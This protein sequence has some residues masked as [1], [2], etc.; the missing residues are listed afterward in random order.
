MSN[1]HLMERPE[2]THVIT[3][4]DV[5]QWTNIYPYSTITVKE[6][7]KTI[8]EPESNENTNHENH[9]KCISF[10]K[11]YLHRYFS[12]F[13]T[14]AKRIFHRFSFHVFGVHFHFFCAFLNLNIAV[15]VVVGDFDCTRSMK[16]TNRFCDANVT[17]PL[18]LCLIRCEFFLF[19][20]CNAISICIHDSNCNRYSHEALGIRH[21]FFSSFSFFRSVDMDGKNFL[22][23]PLQQS[24]LTLIFRFTGKVF[25]LFGI[26]Y[27]VNVKFIGHNQ[28]KLMHKKGIK[29]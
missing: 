13:A 4:R 11:S 26:E 6:N 5:S 23:Y 16:F 24:T 17:A 9:F 28:L 10:D 1:A 7:L 29:K 22:H 3:K 27:D 20:V 15:F 21:S 2:T 25:V 19:G 18:P 8:Q 12:A 14:D